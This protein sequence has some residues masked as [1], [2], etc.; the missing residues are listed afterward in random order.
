MHE[1]NAA[2]ETITNAADADANII[3]G[4]TINPEIEGEV[5]ITVVATG[6]DASYFHGRQAIAGDSSSKVT[7]DETDDSK[8]TRK[9]MLGGSDD[10]AAISDIDMSLANEETAHASVDLKDNEP[11]PNI[12]TLDDDAVDDKHDIVTSSVEE[13]LERPSFLRRLK[14]RKSASDDETKSTPDQ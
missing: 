8:A 10:N 5:I 6:F 9:T 11:V 1:I 13:E 7:D 2:A 12:W 3:F 4:A 14:K